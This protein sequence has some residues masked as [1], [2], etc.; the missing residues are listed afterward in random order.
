MTAAGFSEDDAEELI[1]A[2]RTDGLLPA[3]AATV[4]TIASTNTTTTAVPPVVVAS[5]SHSTA[6]PAADVASVNVSY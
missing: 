1:E 5:S 4:T 3:L 2:L 6:S